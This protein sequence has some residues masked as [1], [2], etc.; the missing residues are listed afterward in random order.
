MRSRRRYNWP[1]GGE[2]LCPAMM[3]RPHRIFVPREIRMRRGRNFCWVFLLPRPS[4][5]PNSVFYIWGESGGLENFPGSFGL[6]F[7]SS[8]SFLSLCLWRK[9]GKE[10]G[11]RK[12][13][14]ISGTDLVHKVGI[15]NPWHIISIFFY[16]LSA[17][18][19]KDYRSFLEIQ[20]LYP[21]QKRKL[22]HLNQ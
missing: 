13:N 9:W 4:A 12:F 2:T 5:Q 6:A 17:T 14:G 1:W 15:S 22:R 18:L 20:S 3:P 19:A 11:G 8:P 7:A 16:N 21:T 10:E